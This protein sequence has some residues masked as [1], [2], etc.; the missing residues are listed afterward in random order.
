MRGAKEAVCV[1]SVFLVGL[2]GCDSLP[3]WGS[4]DPGAVANAVL[5]ALSFA[6][7]AQN[8]QIYY[9]AS[10]DTT[11]MSLQNALRGLGLPVSVA[12]DPTGGV[13][14]ASATPDGTHFTLVVHSDQGTGGSQQ[15]RVTIE[16][17][18]SADSQHGFQIL[19]QL[20]V[21]QPEK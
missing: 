5:P 6:V 17:E 16:W 20:Q 14:I 8:G 3:K 4:V 18:N 1:A 9:S 15:T 19:I 21:Q 10:V 7:L 13:R 2:V 11:S 12:Q